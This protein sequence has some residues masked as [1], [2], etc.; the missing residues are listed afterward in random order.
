MRFPLKNKTCRDT[1]TKREYYIPTKKITTL[2]LEM[3]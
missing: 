3:I 1:I 2:M